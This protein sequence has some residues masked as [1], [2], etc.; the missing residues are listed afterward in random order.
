[1]GGGITVEGESRGPGLIVLSHRQVAPLLNAREEGQSAAVTSLDLGLTESEVRLE[2]EGVAFP[3]GQRLP[4]GG[5]EEIREGE[6]V[7]FVVQDGTVEKVQFFSEAFNRFYS[8]M[9]TDRAPTMLLSGI[10]MHRIKGIDPHEDTLRKIRT[11]APVTGR[12]LDTTTGLGYTA[13]EAAKTASEVVTIEIDPTVLEVA[14][15]NPWSQALFTRPNIRQVIGDSFEEIQ[16][17]EDEGFSRIFHD[18]PTFRLA[19]DLYSGAFYRQLFRV[20]KRGGRLFHYIGDLE[21]ALGSSV[22]KGAV[23]RLQEAGFRRVARHPEA[24]GLVCDK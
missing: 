17:L 4:W 3:Y 20:L 10:P 22:A 5:I 11:I 9:A 7:C 15:R 2:P 12:V 8:L 1:M 21:S 24:F 23:R 6:P 18:P 16:G 19:G 13:I 14:R